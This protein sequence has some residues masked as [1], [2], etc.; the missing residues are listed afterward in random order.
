MIS[1]HTRKRSEGSEYEL[2]NWSWVVLEGNPPQLIRGGFVSPVSLKSSRSLSQLIFVCCWGENKKGDRGE[3]RMYWERAGKERNNASSHTEAY[4]R[5]H[6]GCFMKSSSFSSPEQLRG[7]R[8]R[9]T[10]K[11]GKQN[12][13]IWIWILVWGKR[14]RVWK[15][16]ERGAEMSDLMSLLLLWCCLSEHRRR[17]AQ[18]RWAEKPSALPRSCWHSSV[19][20]PFS[21]DTAS[22]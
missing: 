2:P 18:Q 12:K 17:G 6:S 8:T 16:L 20:E 5:S 11:E 9:Q 22:S 13:E 3:Q 1:R 15:D 14:G 7:T 19:W 21:D 4:A 10:K